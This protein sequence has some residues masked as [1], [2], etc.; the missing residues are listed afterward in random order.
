M[1]DKKEQKKIVKFPSWLLPHSPVSPDAPV[2]EAAADSCDIRVMWNQLVAGYGLGGATDRLRSAMY[3]PD[4]FAD[5]SQYDVHNAATDL[6]NNA[7]YDKQQEQEKR[8]AESAANQ[9]EQSQVSEPAPAPAAE[10]SNEK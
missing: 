8:A 1:T 6:A 9:Q 2:N 3:N 10:Q 4:N 5:V 7:I